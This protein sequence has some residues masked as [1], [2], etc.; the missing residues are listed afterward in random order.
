EGVYINVERRAQHFEQMVAAPGDATGDAWQLIEI[1]RRLGFQALF[2]YDRA[3][4]VEQIWE[5]FARFHAGPESALPP[6]AVLRAQPGAM[7]PYVGGR[8]TRWRYNADHDPAAKRTGEGFDFYG[9]PDHRAWIWLRPYEA[10]AEIPD[11][12][13]PFWLTTGAVLEHWGSGAMT[14]RIPELQ[15]ALPHSYVE[16]KREDARALGIRNRERVRLV[17]RRGAVEAE[18]RLDYRSQPPHNTLFA[19]DFDEGVP[20][21][22]LTLDAFCPV[23][24]Q[25]TA[26]RCAVRIERLPAPSGP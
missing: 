2:P 25:P 5:E 7:W 17:S 9:H 24:G 16:M 12:T 20:V 1:A 14:R 15:R 10:P 6:L 8:E 18:V 22:R 13:Y 4:H 23:S 19:P 21:S 3:R 11:A 26:D